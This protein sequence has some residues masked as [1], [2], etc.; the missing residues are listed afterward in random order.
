[1]QQRQLGEPIPHSWSESDRFVPRA[2][3]RPARRFMAM[4]ASG[5]V[6]MLLAAVVALAWA[7]SPFADVYESLW[8]TTFDLR[9]GDVVHV[10]LTLREWVNDAAMALFFFVVGMEIKR[11]LVVGELRDRRAAL[12]PAVAAVGGMVVPALLYLA[13]NAGGAGQGGWGIP[14]ATD[15]AFAVGVVALLGRRVPVAAK[16]FL[17][18]LAIVDDLGAIVVI[19]VF[20]TAGL[21]AGWLAVAAGAV[22][23]AVLL[24]RGDIRSLVPYTVLGVVAW[25]AL[26]EAGVHAT[27]AGVA[28]GLLTP[29]W[30]FYD[31]ARFGSRARALVDE[32][33]RTFADGGIDHDAYERNDARLRDLVRLSTETSSPLERLE[34]RLAPWVSFVVVPVFA[35][36]NAGVRLSGEMLSGALG[37]PVV[38]GVAVGLVVGKTV[39]IVSATW[40]ACRLGV[41]RLPAGT[42]W[43]H[44]VGLATCAG[45]GFTVALFVA[46]LS[47]TD[48]ALTDA[49]KLGIL[50]GSLVAGVLA[51]VVL[52]SA[53]PVPPVAPPAAPAVRGREP[54][55][56]EELAP[57]RRAAEALAPRGV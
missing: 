11:E 56:D 41:G 22:V 23:G 52:R 16:L 55:P 27:L 28:F 32:I 20:Y 44:L 25:L 40:L 47:F 4:E 42:T 26:H 6:V 18:T 57:P 2:F 15:I 45:I 21:S 8:E 14:M 24:R 7:N 49:A 35:L 50:G 31:P 1:V 43:R 34:Y 12:L 54:G 39:G 36:A 53:P 46:G 29:V 19:A 48:P 17:L 3:V 38:L 51:V 9:L 37:N 5:G 30:S 10:D 13:F 33:D